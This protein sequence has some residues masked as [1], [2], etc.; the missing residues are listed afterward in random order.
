VATDDDKVVYDVL[1]LE[2]NREILVAA[3]QNIMPEKNWSRR[4]DNYKRMTIVA[5]AKTDVDAHVDA[6]FREALPDTA[7]ANIDRHGTLVDVERK[8]E[9]PA[10]APDAGKITGLSGSSWMVTDELVH[11]SGLRFRPSIGGTLDAGGEA[12]VGI[13]AIDTGSQTRLSSG[14][15]LTW[16]PT[17][18]TGL[19]DDVELVADLDDA[20]EDTESI[21]AYRT[22]ILERWSEGKEGG[23][24]SDWRQWVLG[25]DTGVDGIATA[26]IYPN[27]AGVGSVDVA[28]LKAGSGAARLLDAG[29]IATLLAYLNTVRPIGATARVLEVV[30]QSQDVEAVIQPESGGTFGPDWDDA[31]P[32]EVLTWTAATRTLMFTAARPPSMDVGDRLV[33]D[34]TS[35]VELKIEALSGTDGVILEDALGQTPAAGMDV[36]SGGP[37]TTPVR[38]AI[39]DHFDTLGPRVGPYGLG[40]WIS[41][42][43]HAHLFESVQTTAGVLDHDLTTPADD[44]EPTAETYLNETEVALLIAGDVLVRYA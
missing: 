26:Y 13:V 11:K 41:T 22:R 8:A 9:S 42:L 34:G 4:S 29:E 36:Y 17:T 33:I 44:V 28:A 23:T 37:L 25:A 27:R 24:A 40:D 43:R 32:P 21:G 6:C 38:Q 16:D 35:G 7:V 10:S 20:G 5:L 30:T 3:G 14:E 39:L 12:V 2:A 18:P 19:E 1:D 15:I 31:T